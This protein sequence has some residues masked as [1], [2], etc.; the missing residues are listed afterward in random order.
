MR[1]LSVYSPHELAG[2][3]LSPL[4][5]GGGEAETVRLRG[6]L[7]FHWHHGPYAPSA[8]GKALELDAEQTRQLHSL[9]YVQGQHN[10]ARKTALAARYTRRRAALSPQVDGSVFATEP[11]SVDR[12]Q[13]SG[14]EP[15]DSPPLASPCPRTP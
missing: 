6:R 13:Q 10:R 9:G 11:S 3:S 7:I 8:G 14:G 12:A 4:L 2:S 15:C 5:Q 1:R